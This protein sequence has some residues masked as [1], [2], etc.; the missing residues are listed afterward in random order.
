MTSS[1]LTRGMLI[2]K[3]PSGKEEILEERELRKGG[4]GIC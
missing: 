1:S 2:K 3:S 4:R